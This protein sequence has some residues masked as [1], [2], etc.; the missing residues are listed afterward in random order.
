[1]SGW[2]PRMAPFFVALGFAVGCGSS[3]GNPD[4]GLEAGP[5]GKTPKKDGGPHEGGPLDGGPLDGGPHDGHPDD[6]KPTDSNPGDSPT[7]D[8]TTADAPPMDAGP[9]CHKITGE[10]TTY[11]CVSPSGASAGAVCAEAGYVPGPCPSAGLLGCCT[12][13]SGN[14]I[15]SYVSDGVPAATEM[16][17]C[18]ST[19]GTWS[20]TAP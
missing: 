16:S 19:G 17:D 2:S 3:S 6:G 20:T 8:V 7:K 11:T 5:D 9:S 10:A 14:A 4:A 13:S 1:M 15:C 18:T 12:Y